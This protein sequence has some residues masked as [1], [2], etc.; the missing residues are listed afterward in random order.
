MKTTI[1]AFAFFLFVSNVFTQNQ[2]SKEIPVIKVPDFAGAGIKSFYQSYTDHLIKCIKAVREKDE[3][4]AKALFKNPGEQL[5]ARE[6]TLSKEVVKNAVEK[7]KYIQFAEQV[8]PYIKE[9]E[10][11]EYYKKLYGK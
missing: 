1:L 7:Q 9:V 10:H 5:V 3:A 11:S 4:K 6:K 8:Y 2:T